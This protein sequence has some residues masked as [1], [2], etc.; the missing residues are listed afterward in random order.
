[1]K[2]DISKFT[3]A[4]SYLSAIGGHLTCTS[5]NG[6]SVSWGNPYWLHMHTDKDGKPFVSINAWDVPS[7]IQMYG[8]IGYCNENDITCT[9][10]DGVPDDTSYDVEEDE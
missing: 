8:V 1:M 10:D 3:W 7:E 4:V 2:K 6:H 9:I 5:D